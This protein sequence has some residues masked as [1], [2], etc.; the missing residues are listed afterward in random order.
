MREFPLDMYI[1]M[2]EE[3]MDYKAHYGEHFSKKMYHFACFLLKKKNKKNNAMEKAVPVTIEF[4]EGK[5]KEHNIEIEN[6]T[7]YDACY[8]WSKFDSIFESVENEKLI[9]Y[10]IKDYID[11]KGKRMGFVFNEFYAD[12]CYS[13]IPIDW[14]SMI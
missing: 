3:M 6:N 7:L 12:C 8:L 14:E 9:L 5:M 2:P 13:G 10:M 1:R 4:L 11:Q